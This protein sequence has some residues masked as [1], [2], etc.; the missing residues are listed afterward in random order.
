MNT[1]KVSSSSINALTHITA[2]V[3]INAFHALNL[4]VNDNAIGGQANFYLTDEG[5]KLFQDL[6][7]EKQAQI[8][9]QIMIEYDL[10]AG[11]GYSLKHLD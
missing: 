6:S 11:E 8:Q 4:T 2:N 5:A 7:V 10:V 3:K 1:E 9:D